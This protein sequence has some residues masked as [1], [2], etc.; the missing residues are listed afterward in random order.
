[1]MNNEQKVFFY[2]NMLR[3]LQGSTFF[4]EDTNGVLR[5]WHP[6]RPIP[7]LKGEKE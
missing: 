4:C 7:T 3:D 6:P 5:R 2:E 1:M